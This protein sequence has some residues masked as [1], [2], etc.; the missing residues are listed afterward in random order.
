MYP[1]R[2]SIPFWKFTGGMPA[3]LRRLQQQRCAPSHSMCQHKPGTGY[4]ER[5][6]V[7]AVR[8]GRISLELL[9]G[10]SGQ[11][12]CLHVYRTPGSDQLDPSWNHWRTI[13]PSHTSKRLF[14]H[15]FLPLPL[16]ANVPA[17]ITCWMLIF[18]RVMSVAGLDWWANRFQQFPRLS[19]RQGHVACCRSTRKSK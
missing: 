12:F 9:L 8:K 10:R 6:S 18:D 3:I 11:R 5:L 15:H 2:I 14:S 13:T 7:W 17:V 4:T 16:I 19:G 1:F